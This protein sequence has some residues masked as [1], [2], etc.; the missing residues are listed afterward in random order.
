[1]L[2]VFYTQGELKFFEEKLKLKQ[3][4]RCILPAQ[5]S[6][7]IVKPPTT[8]SEIFV[9]NSENPLVFIDLSLI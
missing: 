6:T 4:S 5:T 9:A 7:P 3:T 8:M 2:F 1:M